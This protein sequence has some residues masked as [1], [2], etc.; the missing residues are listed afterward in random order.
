MKGYGK[1]KICAKK[2]VF[3]T[4]ESR[5]ILVCPIFLPALAIFV[6][7]KVRLMPKNRYLNQ[8]V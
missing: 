1:S 6:L 4:A 7:E 2:A 5:I 8:G 3:E